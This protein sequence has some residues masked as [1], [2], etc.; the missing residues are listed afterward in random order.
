MQAKPV[1]LA[2]ALVRA[3]FNAQLSDQEF[4]EIARGLANRIVLGL[5]G[6]LPPVAA[7][8]KQAVPRAEA[9]YRYVKVSTPTGA[10]TSL[11]LRHDD[12]AR[13]S[14]ALGGESEVIARA[15]RL[16]L[17]WGPERGL[18]RTPWVRSELIRA[19]ARSTARVGRKPGAKGTKQDKSGS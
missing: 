12:L 5:G 8:P 3:A 9:R 1:N 18:K 13:M 17:Q 4:R 10:A 15:R 7:P 2:Q 11:S 16:A 19:A 14:Q 6:K